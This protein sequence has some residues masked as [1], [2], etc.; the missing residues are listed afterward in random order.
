MNL[1]RTL[2]SSIWMSWR[3]R[4]NMNN[5]DIPLTHDRPGVSW[6]NIGLTPDGAVLYEHRLTGEQLRYRMRPKALDGGRS[7]FVRGKPTRRTE[8]LSDSEIIQA[9]TDDPTHKK[10]KARMQAAAQNQKLSLWARRAKLE[11]AWCSK[12]MYGQIATARIDW[13]IALLRHDQSLVL[14]DPQ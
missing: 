8:P 7:D 4:T 1:S 6:R 5:T 13:I 2:S 11:R 10:L 14:D 3:M 12:F 9:L